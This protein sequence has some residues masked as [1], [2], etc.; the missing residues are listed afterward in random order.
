[1]RTWQCTRVSGLS[2]DV[3]FIYIH[4]PDNEIWLYSHNM[5]SLLLKISPPWPLYTMTYGRW[6]IHGPVVNTN[7]Q[8]RWENMSLASSLPITLTDGAVVG[9]YWRM[10]ISSNLISCLK[11]QRESGSSCGNND[12]I[13]YVHLATQPNQ[14]SRDWMF[15]K[16]LSQSAGWFLSL[17]L[18][19]ILVSPSLVQY[20]SV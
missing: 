8:R 14:A 11:R 9:R 16:M 17:Q 12:I 5:C 3:H 13:L 15:W 6:K 10:H 20:I 2:P 7:L 1:M 18:F 19:F 4:S